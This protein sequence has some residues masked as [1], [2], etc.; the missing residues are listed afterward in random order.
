[1]SI[2]LCAS[3]PAET[4]S[5]TASIPSSFQTS[6][7]LPQ[8]SPSIRS[9][10][11]LCSCPSSPRETVTSSSEP[12][13]RTFPSFRTSQPWSVHLPALLSS[14]E[15]LA[16][17]QRADREVHLLIIT[18]I[19]TLSK[20]FGYPTQK[21]RIR[22]RLSPSDLFHSFFL[23]DKPLSRRL[24]GRRP[25][26]NIPR[27]SSE[28]NELPHSTPL[29]KNSS[30]DGAS[31]R[32]NLPERRPQVRTPDLH[33]DPQIPTNDFDVASLISSDSLSL[34]KAVVITGLE[35]AGTLAQRALL[36]ALSD[37]S[38]VLED[39]PEIVWKLPQDFI[40]VYVCANDAWERPKIHPSLV[41]IS[42]PPP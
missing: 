14:P 33:T 24:V 41:N 37:Q 36:Q 6:A 17:I 22:S 7:L 19:Q 38:F 12:P 21:V 28:L 11:D 20:P 32:H 15:C 39:D 26:R 8:T 30:F 3:P 23:G 42:F 29:S 25:L 13:T 5:P 4:W 31:T 16:S 1:M 40:V 35:F 34:P 10:S 18:T 2:N 27:T 9:S